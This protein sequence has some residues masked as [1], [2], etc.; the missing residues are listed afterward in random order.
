MSENTGRKMPNAQRRDE[1]LDNLDKAIKGRERK[2]KLA[3]L[4][5]MVTTVV[6]LAAIVGGIYFA[7]TYTGSDDSEDQ[8]ETQAQEEQQ[9]PPLPNGPMKAYP[10]EVS[11]EY[12]DEGGA[13][14]QVDKPGTENIPTDGLVKVNL[15]TTAGEIPIELDR[16]TSPCSVNSFESLAKQNYFDNTVCHRH[17]KSDQM[18]ILQCGDPTGKGTGGPGYKFDDEFPLNGVAEGESQSPLTYP[19]GTLAMANS[20]PDTNGSQFFLVTRDTTL[21][22][23]YNVFGKIS[24]E[25]LATLDKI[26]DAAPEGDGK[27]ADE[28]KIEKA[29]VS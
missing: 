15:K 25:G 18:G 29:T 8:T 27:P 13:A 1:A 17:V 2:A 19:R 28:V 23:A 21:P 16:G 14:K 22:P 6:V 11:C 26:Y 4:G 9:Y 3:P 7:S 5:V 12:E 10:K 20:G 24:D